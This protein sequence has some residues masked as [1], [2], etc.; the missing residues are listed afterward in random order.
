VSR[1]LVVYLDTYVLS[2]LAKL[3]LGRLKQMADIGRAEEA[4]AFFTSLVDSRVAIFPDSWT[5]QYEVEL[6]P[7]RTAHTRPLT[8]D[9]RTGQHEVQLKGDPEFEDAVR[10]VA[11][12]LSRGVQFD[13]EGRIL[14]EQITNLFVAH[15][16]GTE[17]VSTWHEAFPYDPRGPIPSH[18]EEDATHSWV[19]GSGQRRQHRRR[20]KTLSAEYREERT[21]QRANASLDYE[22][23]KR[24]NARW[25]LDTIA[26]GALRRSRSRKPLGFEDVM[27]LNATAD[28]INVA[29]ERGDLFAA[30]FWNFANSDAILKAPLIDI[31]ASIEA[32]IE[33]DESSRKWEPGDEYDLQALSEV[34]PYC[35]A[36]FCDG[37]MKGKL[38]RHGIA[39]TYG[40][41]V[42]SMRD[43]DQFRRDVEAGPTGPLKAMDRHVAPIAERWD[44][45][46][47]DLLSVV[48]SCD[49]CRW[50]EA[51][52]YPGWT[53]KDLLAHLATGFSVRLARLRS[54]L[55]TGQPGPEPDADAA[56]AEAIARHRESSPEALVEEM[57]RQRSE[58]RRLM[59]L[60]R[61]E[62]LEAR[63]LMHRRGQAPQEGSFLEAL[64]HWHEH[65]VE[66]AADLSPIMRWP[67]APPEV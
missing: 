38:R 24:A 57:V 46:T 59:G 42:Y 33:V 15:L 10:K 16:D 48:R 34:L 49:P 37:G 50:G 36:V 32:C 4:L 39:A 41:A 67:V 58:M 30:S 17:Y 40:T 53:Y 54:L 19:E 64:Q 31:R 12:R 35:D 60:L 5:R 22:E 52:P 47:Q 63:T 20:R 66:H 3:K 23:I 8:P 55:E 6:K 11:A 1:R 62:H 9:S 61:P 51:S 27:A 21:Q 2:D 25:Y 43:F 29:H 18:L 56:N 45:V 28:A 65:D 26:L 14:S 7:P 44:R 13:I